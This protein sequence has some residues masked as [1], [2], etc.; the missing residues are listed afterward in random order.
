MSCEIFLKGLFFGLIGLSLGLLANYLADVLPEKRKLAL[1]FC[2][3][4]GNTFQLINYLF[5]PRKC[6]HCGNRRK[7][8]TW[9]VELISIIFG[10]WI[11]LNTPINLGIFL[12]LSLLLYFIVVVVIDI[13]HHLILHLTS[14][15][16]FILSIIIG[17]ILHGY[18]YTLIGG[19]VGFSIMLI[20]YYFGVLFSRICSRVRKIE[21]EE[22]ALGFGDV[23]LSGIMGLLL[24]YPGVI[25]GLLFAI[26]L[27]GLVSLVFLMFLFLSKSYHPNSTLPYGPFLVLSTFCL[28]FLK[29]TIY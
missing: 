6:K 10:V 20:L 1:P 28:L 14:I 13:E 24:G 19:A 16:G 12:S 7:S 22:E 27:G 5:Y 23:I 25:V 29:G 4:C 18:V 26:L 3:E 8:R 9:I 21:L 11:G 15:V 2:I 17:I